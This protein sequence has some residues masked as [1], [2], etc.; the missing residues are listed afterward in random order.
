[1]VKVVGHSRVR[2]K[3]T[4]SFSQKRALKTYNY[5]IYEFWVEYRPLWLREQHPTA[6]AAAAVFWPQINLCGHDAGPAIAS[7]DTD[8][9][10]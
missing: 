1:M 3:K 8:M 6:A 4:C 10:T 2:E 5:H 9:H 7:Y